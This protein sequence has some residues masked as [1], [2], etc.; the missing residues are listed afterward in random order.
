[1]GNY[2]DSEPVVLTATDWTP[3][4]PR[5]RTTA[6]LCTA[7]GTAMVD[8]LGVQPG[9]PGATNQAIPFAV[10]QIID[11]AFLKVRKTGTTGTF[12]ALY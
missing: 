7:A 2:A 4:A 11:G 1:M 6:L 12:V 10:N 3:T 5:S 8:W 9:Q